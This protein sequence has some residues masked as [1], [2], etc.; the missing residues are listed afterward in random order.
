M[1]ANQ[2]QAVLPKL[3]HTVL[4]DLEGKKIAKIRKIATIGMSRSY[5]SIQNC[6]LALKQ[7]FCYKIL[8]DKSIIPHQQNLSIFFSLTHLRV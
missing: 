5:S 1:S 4:L 2:A 8:F 7:C 3:Y 6:L